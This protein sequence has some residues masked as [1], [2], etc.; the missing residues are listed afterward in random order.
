MSFGTPRPFAPSSYPI[1]TTCS[2][3]AMNSSAMKA[4]A[5]TGPTRAFYLHVLT[6]GTFGVP[7]TRDPWSEIAR[8]VAELAALSAGDLQPS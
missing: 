8:H 2:L 1:A 4:A 5:G 3:S 7:G 6:D